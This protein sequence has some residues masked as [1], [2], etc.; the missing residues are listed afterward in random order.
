VAPKFVKKHWL[1]ITESKFTPFFNVLKQG[2]QTRGPLR[3]FMRP[4]LSSKLKISIKFYWKGCGFYAGNGQ[5]L[6][7]KANWMKKKHYIWQDMWHS[8][9][10]SINCSP[11]GT[12]CFYLRPA[13]HFFMLMRPLSVFEF[14]TSV[15][16][17]SNL[18]NLLWG[19]SKPTI[20]RKLNSWNFYIF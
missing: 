4:A 18:N 10:S 1:K 8:E 14:E 2:S 9:P 16:K 12:F 3:V 19:T 17:Y 20:T 13:E 7:L 15:L 11:Q 6:A 5:K